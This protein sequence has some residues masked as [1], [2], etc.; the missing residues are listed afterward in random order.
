MTSNQYISTTKGGVYNP[1]GQVQIL[2]KNAK[3]G[4]DISAFNQ[5]AS[6]VLYERGMLFKVVGVRIADGKHYILMEECNE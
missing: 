5:N 4:R 2:I 3:R 6:E 1:E